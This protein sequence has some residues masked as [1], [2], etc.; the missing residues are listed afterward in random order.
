MLRVFSI[1]IL[2][3]VTLFPGVSSGVWQSA[4]LPSGVDTPWYFHTEKGFI[5]IAYKDG[6]GREKQLRSPCQ[7][8]P[9]NKDCKE[10]VYVFTK[11]EIEYFIH[12]AFQRYQEQ[13][14]THQSNVAIGGMVAVWAGRGAWTSFA[15][16][17]VALSKLFA[18]GSA[19]L[20]GASGLYVAW[21]GNSI[22]KL[23][24]RME[25]ISQLLREEENFVRR[26]GHPRAHFP[27]QLEKL[28]VRLLFPERGGRFIAANEYFERKTRDDHLIL[29]TAQ[30][31]KSQR[32]S[33]VKAKLRVYDTSCGQLPR[34]KGFAVRQLRERARQLEA[35]SRPW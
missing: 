17:E 9:S 11:V 7:L 35:R 32:L 33:W 26:C 2:S 31:Q 25:A 10:Q 4:S 1:G 14:R 22:R 15:A 24:Q 21:E 20:A 28:G 13:I 12:L 29:S 3:F 34:V 27:R 19:A 23:V 6:F 16:P 5:D 8:S 30:E 18:V